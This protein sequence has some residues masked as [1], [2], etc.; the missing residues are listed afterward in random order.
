ML[1]S[2]QEIRE[3]FHKNFLKARVF[4][5]PTQC[6]YL[7]PKGFLRSRS[8]VDPDPPRSLWGNVLFGLLKSEENVKVSGVAEF[9]EPGCR[10]DEPRYGLW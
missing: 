7:L 9:S 4:T 8:N 6:L 2:V 10:V 5:S 3:K 1:R